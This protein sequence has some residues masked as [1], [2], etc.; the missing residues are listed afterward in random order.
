MGRLGRWVDTVEMG[1]ARSRFVLLFGSEGRSAFSQDV[2][3]VKS[4]S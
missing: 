3:A 4:V 2:A 1:M